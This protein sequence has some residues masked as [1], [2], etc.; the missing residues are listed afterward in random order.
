ML[1]SLQSLPAARAL[2]QTALLRLDAGKPLVAPLYRRFGLTPADQD[3]SLAIGGSNQSIDTEVYANDRLLRPWLVW[4]LAH[5]QDPAIAE[6]NF[7]Q[8]T[9]QPDGSGNPNP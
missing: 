8:P 7:H 9:G 1:A 2:D 3:G 4:Y 5:K 6:P